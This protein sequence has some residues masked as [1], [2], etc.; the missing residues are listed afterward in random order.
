VREFPYS[1]T[2]KKPKQKRFNAQLSDK[3]LI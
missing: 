1:K 3:P 2:L